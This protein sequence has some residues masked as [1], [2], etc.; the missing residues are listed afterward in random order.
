MF[1]QIIA[2]RPPGYSAD[3]VMDYCN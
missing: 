1:Q 2:L 3:F